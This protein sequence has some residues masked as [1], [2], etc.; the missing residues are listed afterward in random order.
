MLVPV[1]ECYRLVRNICSS[2][3]SA[4]TGCESTERRHI[5]TRFPDIDL[6]LA[7]GN[8]VGGAIGEGLGLN[9]RR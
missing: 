4:N 9:R 5:L 3:Q 1:A 8:V 2:S 7:E 6:A